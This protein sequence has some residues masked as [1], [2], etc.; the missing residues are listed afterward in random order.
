MATLHSAVQRRYSGDTAVQ[1]LYGGIWG[2]SIIFDPTHDRLIGLPTYVP[3]A[4][5]SEEGS[6][7]PGL[8]VRLDSTKPRLCRPSF[9]AASSLFALTSAYCRVIS[10]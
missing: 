5:L 9:Q 1:H 10:Y 4:E 2:S 3:A 7:L 8:A 6:D